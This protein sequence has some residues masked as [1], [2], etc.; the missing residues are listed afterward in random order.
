MHYCHWKPKY[1]AS[2]AVLLVR[3]DE[4]LKEIN[5]WTGQH[6]HMWLYYLRNTHMCVLQYSFSNIRVPT[7]PCKIK[8]EQ[9]L[10]QNGR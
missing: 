1:Q 7:K 2:F 6:A 8:S 5:P 9:L 4:V 3:V 10:G